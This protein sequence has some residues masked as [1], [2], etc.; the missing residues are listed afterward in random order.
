MVLVLKIPCGHGVIHVY[1]SAKG[2]KATFNAPRARKFGSQS[3]SIRSTVAALFP[4]LKL[5]QEQR[6]AVW[7]AALKVTEKVQPALSKSRKNSGPAAV[8]FFKKHPFEGIV[9]PWGRKA[10]DK[11]RMALNRKGQDQRLCSKKWH[12]TS[13]EA[14][15]CI[16]DKCIGMG[17][18]VPVQQ[19]AQ[20]GTGGFDVCGANGH[21]IAVAD[22]PADKIFVCIKCGAFAHRR[23]KSLKQPC[24]PRLGQVSAKP[25]ASTG[26]VSYKCR[27]SVVQVSFKCHPSAGQLSYKR[28]PNGS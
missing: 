4:E 15:E 6:D 7:A 8:V 1:G 14:F 17:R 21:N 28:C 5:T 13:E 19:Q 3:K 20:P 18:E 16:R 9:R 27:S 10:D 25:R 12:S 22:G 26:Q 2:Y 24:H 11:V 23:W